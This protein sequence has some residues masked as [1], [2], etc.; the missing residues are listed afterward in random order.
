MIIV[1]WLTQVVF[2]SIELRL[3]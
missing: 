2:R 3:K 1:V